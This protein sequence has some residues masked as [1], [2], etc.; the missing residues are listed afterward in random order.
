M[1]EEAKRQLIAYPRAARFMV[2]QELLL[3][4]DR[5]VYL[6]ELTERLVLEMAEMERQNSA[7]LSIGTSAVAVT[8]EQLQQKAAIAQSSRWFMRGAFRRMRL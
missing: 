5:R 3:N 2:F 1:H 6:I 8:E 7:A 4:M